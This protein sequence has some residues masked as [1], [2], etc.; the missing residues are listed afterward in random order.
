[1]LAT[2]R[3]SSLRDWETA[4]S[5]LSNT[6]HL[7]ILAYDVTS[8]ESY[9]S[10]IRRA[11]AAGCTAPVCLVGLKSDLEDQR[12]VDAG[13]AAGY[14]AAKGVL[15][16][17]VNILDLDSVAN[18]IQRIAEKVLLWRS[19]MVAVLERQIPAIDCPVC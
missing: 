7:R 1:M 11:D 2:D 16:Q 9:E 3:R 13:Q 6:A 8:I 18:V 10:A 4:N 19:S 15:W 14:C 5:Q 17:E 12:E